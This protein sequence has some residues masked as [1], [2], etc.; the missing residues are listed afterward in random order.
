[1]TGLLDNDVRCRVARLH[2]REA[3]EIA[4]VTTGDCQAR[5]AE[6][7]AGESAEG[8]GT[9]PFGTRTTDVGRIAGVDAAMSGIEER[10]TR[11]RH[12]GT[13]DD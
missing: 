8:V 5:V 3:N 11:T 10:D 4:G 7:C 2:P 13:L 12:T 9:P 6:S 1:M